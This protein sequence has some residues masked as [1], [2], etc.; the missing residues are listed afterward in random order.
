MCDPSRTKCEC[1]TLTSALRALLECYQ[2]DEEDLLACT[3][4]FKQDR[5]VLKSTVGDK[6]LHEFVTHTKEHKDKT[7]RTKH[8]EI[9]KGSFESW[10]AHLHVSQ[11]NWNKCRSLLDGFNTQ[12][13]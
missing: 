8:D 6:P 7:D 10:M 2:T 1:A 4:R 5:D 9:A 3:Q 11:A 13:S 12:C